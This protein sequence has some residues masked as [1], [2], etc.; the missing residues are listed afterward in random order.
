MQERELPPVNFAGSF[1]MTDSFPETY[2][3][4]VHA[5][6]ASQ[7]KPGNLSNW[8][9]HWRP[10]FCSLISRHYVVCWRKTIKNKLTKKTKLF[11]CRRAMLSINI[12][13][14]NILFI[15]IGGQETILKNMA[16]YLVPAGMF[17]ISLMFLK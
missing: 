1:W 14:N 15:H 11:V 2:P 16:N 12:I 4:N 5:K 10:R 17:N 7:R 13:Q 8:D 3:G 9:I 6:T